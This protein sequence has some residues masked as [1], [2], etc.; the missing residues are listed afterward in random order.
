MAAYRYVFLDLDR[1]LWDFE[2]NNLV[3]FKNLY[4]KYG[5]DGLFPNFDSFYNHYRAINDKL[6]EDYREGRIDKMTLRWKRFQLT[7]QLAGKDNKELAEQI[8]DE[9]IRTSPSGKVLMPGTI[10]LL[11]NLKS[12]YPLYILTNGFTEVQF[13]KLK[14]CELDSYFQ[15]VFTSEEA[16]VQKPNRA[17]FDFVLKE[18][19]ASPSECIMIGDDL[20]V[21]IRGA[22]EAG[23]EGILYC[24]EKSSGDKSPARYVVSD[25]KEILNIL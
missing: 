14:N 4:L 5:L 12:R 20:K 10:E 13:V 15:R 18:I 7:L 17:F 2:T 22:M 6:W 16:G 21:D 25:L 19:K 11:D 1:T 24:P 9:Y 8:G 23:I 3:T